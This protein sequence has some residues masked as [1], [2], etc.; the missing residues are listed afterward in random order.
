MGPGVIT[1]LLLLVGSVATSARG[2][3]VSIRTMTAALVVTGG[4]AEVSARLVD[5]DGTE[6]PGL[7]IERDATRM[8]IVLARS[9]RPGARV[10]V[11]VPTEITL[12]VEASN[13]GPVTVSAVHGQI[14]IVNSNAAI[15]LDAVGGT[16]LAST[17][18]GPIT[19]TLRSIDPA[20]P[21]SFLTSNGAI[22][23]TFPSSL[24]AVLCLETDTGP[25]ASDFALAP[26]GGP[27]DRTMMRGGRLRTLQCGSVN[28]GGTDIRLRTENAPIH[29]RKGP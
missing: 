2:L 23:V 22:D 28:G 10:E 14:E 11:R 29:V 4:A 27:V 1:V 7:V 12:H 15:V 5:S 17:S 21:L 24:K 18:N 8:S 16:V 20:L 9:V 26:A 19:A 25:I 3:D 13:G 6:I